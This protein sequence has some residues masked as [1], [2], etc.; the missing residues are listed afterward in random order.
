SL[1]LALT[2]SLLPGAALASPE[3]DSG[4]EQVAEAVPDEHLDLE[5]GLVTSDPEDVAVSEPTVVTSLT[6][7]PA[8][9]TQA[10]VYPMPSTG[11]YTVTGGGWGH[12]IGMS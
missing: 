5:Y 1:A 9:E 4:R 7:M 10:E 8:A 2:A 3:A 11:Y 12:R 6:E